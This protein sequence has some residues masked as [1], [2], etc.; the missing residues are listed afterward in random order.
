MAPSAT[1]S[2]YV[3]PHLF[4][5]H[6]KAP[7]FATPEGA[8]LLFRQLVSELSSPNANLNAEAVSLARELGFVSLWFLLVGILSTAGPYEKLVDPVS[9][10]MC[11]FRASDAW[12]RPGARAAAFIPRG[13]YKSE[14]AGSRVL[15]PTFWAPVESVLPGDSLVTRYGP[16]RVSAVSTSVEPIFEVI[17]R[18]GRVIRGADHHAIFTFDG[19]RPLSFLK[20]GN[21]VAIDLSEAPVPEPALSPDLNYILGTIYGDGSVTGG[22]VFITNFDADV[23]NRVRAIWPSTRWTP[24]LGRIFLHGGLRWL[25]TLDLPLEKAIHK[26]Y[27]KIAEGST[28]FLRGLYDCDGSVHKNNSIVSFTTAS[29]D[30]ARGVL[31]NLGRLGIFASIHEYAS[32]SPH[33]RAFQ[34][35]IS[36]GF[37]CR[38]F[39][40]LI[41]FTS[42]A[43]AK[44]LKKFMKSGLSIRD[45][46]PPEWR[47]LIPSGFQG[48]LRR[49]GLRIDNTYATSREKVIKVLEA[50]GAELPDVLREPIVFDKIVSVRQ[51]PPE[52]VYHIEVEGAHEYQSDHRI[53]HHNST[54]F[55]H[56]GITWDLLRNPEERIVLVNAIYDK[57]AEFFHQVERNFDSCDL[58]QRLYPEWIPGKSGKLSDK[59]LILPNRRRAAPE[60]NLRPLGLT[61]AAEGGHY[62]LISMDD[63]IG[64][65][66]VDSNHQ[67]T[68]VMETAKK[69]FRTNRRA[70]RVDGNSRV[71]VVATRYAMDDCYEDIYSSCRSLTGYSHEDIVEVPSG[72][73]DIYYRLHEEDGIFIRPD[74]MD[75]AEYE[76][77]LKEDYWAAIVNYGN[78]P[79]QAGLTEFGDSLLGSCELIWDKKDERYW[80]RRLPDPNFPIEEEERE[81]S[82]DSC[83]VIVTTDL[84][85]TEKK[86]DAKTCRTSIAMWAT[87]SVG[88]RY[89][90]WSRVGFF[91]I[92]QTFDY[93]FEVNRTFRGYI[94]TTIIEANAFQKIVA[95]V[96][97]REQEWRGFSFPVWAV[98]ASGDKKARIRA[99]LGQTLPKRLIWLATGAGKEFIEELK[100]FPMSDKKLDTLD[101]SEKAI[102]Y[103]VRP[104]TDEERFA[105]DEEDEE[106]SLE[107]KNAV[108][109]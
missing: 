51:L 91:S 78:A 30:L 41:G 21:F 10:D 27:P 67:A 103:G 80:I 4:R 35:N 7:R 83:D 71:V 28:D 33:G 26:T 94:R 87:D 18:S 61:G 79:K 46:I 70:L 75:K 88:N 76:R 107:V 29:E 64:L 19:F 73:W 96:L 85:A 105:S 39:A 6:P 22:S 1:T 40:D 109:Y 34:V 25:K 42:K 31:R 32:T 48:V 104:A 20:P 56:G 37:E 89:R 77:L 13:F 102:T 95:P 108:G 86:M 38:K 47:D 49:N 68:I 58:F 59:E 69:W 72:E 63:L 84:A 15:T 53:V 100:V 2:Y 74:I 97:R 92:D 44:R 93:L 66:S 99:A 24:K 17:L 43:K 98:N 57:A 101:E 8:E 14:T 5:P 81:I 106:R 52:T 9:V 23:V 11:N 12:M 3:G 60:P 45:Y 16:A 50:C 62:T 54:V 65:D 36:G 55:T 82:L 90:L